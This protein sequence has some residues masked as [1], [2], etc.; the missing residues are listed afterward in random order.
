MADLRARVAALTTSAAKSGAIK[1]LS[2]SGRF[3]RD[4]TTGVY[5]FVSQKSA[6]AEAGRKAA[7]VSAAQSK[8]RFDPFETPEDELVVDYD[9]TATHYLQLNKFPVCDDHLLVVTKGFEWQTDVPKSADFGAIGAALR[10]VDG[11]VFYNC[12]ARSGASIPHKHFQLLPRD[13]L[14][15]LASAAE[16]AALEAG[17]TAPSTIPMEPLLEACLARSRSW[18]TPTRLPPPLD[19][20]SVCAARL[21]D[22]WADGG[23]TASVDVLRCYEKL[24]EA[25]D[26][27]PSRDGVDHCGDTEHP[28]HNMVMTRGWMLVAARACDPAPATGLGCNACGFGGFFLVRDAEQLQALRA[29]GPAQALADLCVALPGAS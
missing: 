11:F 27:P 14:D 16:P 9:L 26:L 24:L 3:V 28:S 15:V 8:T 10:E 12:G 18:G 19:D 29:R 1:K 7:S 20:V 4:S 2:T 17:A 22:G 21:P 6:A 23:A 13:A 5:F 25:C